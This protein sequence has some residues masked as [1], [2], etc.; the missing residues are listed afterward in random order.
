MIGAGTSVN[1]PH[2]GVQKG[3]QE[4]LDLRAARGQLDQ[5]VEGAELEDEILEPLGGGPEIVEHLL[6]GTRQLPD[7]GDMAQS[8]HPLWLAH[9]DRAGL[10][11]RESG[12]SRPAGRSG[13]PFG[14]KRR[15]PGRR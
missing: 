5:L 15:S 4:I 11:G 13:P 7:L 14:E 10:S 12:L 8:R 6:E 1:R 3:R 9:G 2:G